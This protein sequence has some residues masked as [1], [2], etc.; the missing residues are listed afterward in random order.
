MYY[1]KFHIK[2]E[3]GF[4]DYSDFS[5]HDNPDTIDQR[6]IRYLENIFV[7]AE[8]AP[9]SSFGWIVL[10]DEDLQVDKAVREVKLQK[11]GD[12]FVVALKG[13][14]IDALYQI[15]I[16]KESMYNEFAKAITYT[17]VNELPPAAEQPNPHPQLRP[18]TVNSNSVP[19]DAKGNIFF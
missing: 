12:G 4:I 18:I 16:R 8:R 2:T 1:S 9:T 10:E 14:G 7:G 11:N 15:S 6:P 3:K 5:I 13:P 19:A 17:L